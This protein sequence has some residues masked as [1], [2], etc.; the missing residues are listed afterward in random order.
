[1]NRTELV[2]RLQLLLENHGRGGS[3]EP[4]EVTTQRLGEQLHHADHQRGHASDLQRT[5]PA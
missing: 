1:M 2:A 5:A 4:L 3:L